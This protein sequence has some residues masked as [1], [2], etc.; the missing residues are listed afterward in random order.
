MSSTRPDPETIAA[1]RAFTR[2]IAAAIR[3]F[4]AAAL[5]DDRLADRH[6]LAAEII[7]VRTQGRRVI[8]LVCEDGARFQ[9]TID[10]I[11]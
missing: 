9:I 10:P 3:F 1:E 5:A 7:S 4:N 2:T 8:D 6:P 11:D